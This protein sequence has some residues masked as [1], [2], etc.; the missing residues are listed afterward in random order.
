MPKAVLK[1]EHPSSQRGRAGAQKPFRAKPARVT[2]IGESSSDS[3]FTADFAE[4][5]LVATAGS[6]KLS[7]GILA[8]LSGS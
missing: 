4:G 7:D 5:T 6:F 8:K 3:Y 2:L 1:E